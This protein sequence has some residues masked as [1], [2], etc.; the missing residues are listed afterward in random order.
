MAP[1]SQSVV[2]GVTAW[3]LIGT[4]GRVKSRETV[5]V[6]AAAGG[7]GSLAVQL[8][9]RAGAHVIATAS[10]EESASSRGS[11]ARTPQSSPMPTASPRA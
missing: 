1:R 2:Q 9:R 8:A 7:V 11:S 6:H 4:C 10:T 5:V 3:H